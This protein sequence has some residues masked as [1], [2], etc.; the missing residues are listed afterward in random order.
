MDNDVVV[1]IINMLSAFT[2]F[3]NYYLNPIR[4]KTVALMIC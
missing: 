3:D 1:Y 2:D 4:L